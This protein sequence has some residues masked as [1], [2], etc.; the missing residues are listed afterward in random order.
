MPTQ[1]QNS[2]SEGEIQ[3]GAV[4]VCQAVIA[5]A[6]NQIET[7]TDVTAHAEMLLSL[8][9]QI[10]PEGNVPDVRFMSLLNPPNVRRSIGLGTDRTVGFRGIRFRKICA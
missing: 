4:I 2:F 1:R 9:R 3:V 7:L 8:L 6:H 10:Y 5:R